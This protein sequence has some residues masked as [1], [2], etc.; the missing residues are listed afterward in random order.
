MKKGLITSCI[1]VMLA[2]VFSSSRAGAYFVEGGRIFKDAGQELR[3]KGVNWF[4]FE[5]GEHVA[6]GLWV[7]NWLDLIGQI[8]ELGFNAV[9]LPFCP[10][11]LRG[12]AMGGVDYS[13]NQDMEG[14]DSLACLDTN[15]GSR[16]KI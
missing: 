6:H 13:I 4:G 16:L 5:T 11:S 2:G 14:L 1:L 9:R 3:L 8:K 10:A 12:S 15:H 7:R